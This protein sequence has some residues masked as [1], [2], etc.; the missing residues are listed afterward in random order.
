MESVGI[1]GIMGTVIGLL[2]WVLK[3]VLTEMTSAVKEQTAVHIRSVEVQEKMCDKIDK[4]PTCR[5]DES[6]A[7]RIRPVVKSAETRDES[8]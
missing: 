2:G 3:H 8:E 7:G 1:I 4:L 6:I 5:Y